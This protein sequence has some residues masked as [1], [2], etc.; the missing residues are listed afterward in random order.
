M[1]TDA[2]NQ[3][4]AGILSQYHIVKGAERLPSVEYHDRTLSAAQCNWPIYHKELFHIVDSFRKWK[5]WLV[6]VEVNVYTDQQ[7]LQYFYTKQKVNSRQASW[8][9]HMYKFRYNIHFRPGTKMG[10]PDALSRRSGEETS[11]MDAWFLS[12]EQR[13]DFV[14][15]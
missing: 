10:K 15:D 7:D 2:S 12:E 13:L 6:G 3:A 4:V 11:G 8:Y 9:L 5:E 1:E 14:E